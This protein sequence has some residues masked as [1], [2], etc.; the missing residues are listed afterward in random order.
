M[1]DHSECQSLVRFLNSHRRSPRRQR[2]VRNIYLVIT[3]STTYRATVRL[4][5]VVAVFS[6]DSL[7][8]AY[9]ARHRT[10]KFP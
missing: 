8:K 4:L 2:S 7:D 3:V 9:S 1:Y 5:G 6:Q 10:P